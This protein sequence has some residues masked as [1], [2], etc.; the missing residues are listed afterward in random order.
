MKKNIFK[1]IYTT[2]DDRLRLYTAI[3]LISLS[4]M[5]GSKVLEVFTPSLV[6]QYMN[7]TP[8]IQWTFNIGTG[9]MIAAIVLFTMHSVLIAAK[10]AGLFD[11]W[12]R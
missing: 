9:F 8:L 10:K 4:T 12:N 5:A 1:R 7:I 3:F 6:N 11:Q 2:F